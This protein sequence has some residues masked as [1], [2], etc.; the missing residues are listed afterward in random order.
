MYT[1]I[2]LNILSGTLLS[3]GD[4]MD[5]IHSSISFCEP[6]F[7]LVVLWH[8]PIE[9]RKEMY[10]YFE[11]HCTYIS[12][13][14]V[15]E[16]INFN[17]LP[18]YIL[19]ATS[20]SILSFVLYQELFNISFLYSLC[21]VHTFLLDWIGFLCRTGSVRIATVNSIKR[22]VDSRIGSLPCDDIWIGMWSNDTSHEYTVENCECCEFCCI[23]V[24]DLIPIAVYNFY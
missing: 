7:R 1:R 9:V 15:I 6:R 14:L 2:C 12:I 10:C 23:Q 20:Y 11:K 18:V 8:N 5:F 21:T 24:F 13:F 16:S 22:H 17:L 4:C 3:L 19:F